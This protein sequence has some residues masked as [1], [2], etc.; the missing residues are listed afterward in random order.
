MEEIWKPVP[1]EFTYGEEVLASNYGNIIYRGDL[2]IGSL[3]SR[4][5]DSYITPKQPQR[6][7]QDTLRMA[8]HL[9][10]VFPEQVIRAMPGYDVQRARVLDILFYERD[11][12]ISIQTGAPPSDQEIQ[13]QGTLCANSGL[14][15]PAS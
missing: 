8:M 6:N 2:T 12:S 11:F 10:W 5:K 13:R 9:M 7:L 15:Q 14:L 1:T 3:G 4:G